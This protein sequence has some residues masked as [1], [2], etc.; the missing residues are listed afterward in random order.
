MTF[1]CHSI[2]YSLNKLQYSYFPLWN[3]SQ[4]NI[5][6]DVNLF[7]QQKERSYYLVFSVPFPQDL[8]HLDLVTHISNGLLRMYYCII[9][10]LYFGYK[11]FQI[12]MFFKT[13]DVGSYGILAALDLN[14]LFGACNILKHNFLYLLLYLVTFIFYSLLCRLIPLSVSLWND[15][16]DPVFEVVEL[17][18]FNR[19]ANASLLT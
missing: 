2:A 16:G 11:Y 15:F 9:L 14:H 12:A 17:T 13:P 18:G 5:T 6:R 10:I 3:Y 1:S 7:Q 19:R 4:S 8:S